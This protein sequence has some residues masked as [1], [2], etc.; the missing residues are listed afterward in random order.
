MEETT[1]RATLVRLDPKLRSR[2]DKF[3]ETT[4]RTLLGAM[5]QLL[6]EALDARGDDHADRE[7]S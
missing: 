6:T 5:T 1:K 3:A 4:H 7:A 2:V